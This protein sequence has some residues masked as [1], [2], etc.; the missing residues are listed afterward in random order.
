MGKK[1]R[2]GGSATVARDG[3][4]DDEAMMVFV[5]GR[6]CDAGM[7]GEVGSEDRV[8]VSKLKAMM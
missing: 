7:G 2:D 4:D 3:D 6:C 8:A 5:L 1:F